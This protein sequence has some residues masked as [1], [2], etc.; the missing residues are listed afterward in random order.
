VKNAKMKSKKSCELT[1]PLFWHRPTARTAYPEMRQDGTTK[2][3]L[4]PAFGTNCDLMRQGVGDDADR[5]DDLERPSV[6]LVLLIS[7]DMPRRRHHVLGARGVALTGS[8]FDVP[9]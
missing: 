6:T 3:R 5:R 8:V 2:C 9:S 7:I 4:M 1:T